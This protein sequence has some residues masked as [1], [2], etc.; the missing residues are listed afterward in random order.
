VPEFKPSFFVNRAGCQIEIR[1]KN[2]PEYAEWLNPEVTIF[3]DRDTGE[4][5][6][7]E[8]PIPPELTFAEEE[9]QKRQLSFKTFLPA[10]A[11]VHPMAIDP[12]LEPVPVLG[13]KG[14]RIG[15]V[16]S[17]KPT[18]SGEILFN[19]VLDDDEKFFELKKMLEKTNIPLPASMSTA[20]PPP[21]PPPPP[22]K[23]MIKEGQLPKEGDYKA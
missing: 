1:W 2:R 22:P 21:E 16:T 8:I 14:E 13:L 6:G 5:V 4:V 19:I 12:N 10:Q 9:K 15:E 17:A 23:R 7:C 18:E 3:R 11:F 20:P